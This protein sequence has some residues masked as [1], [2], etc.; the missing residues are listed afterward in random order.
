MNN[1]MMREIMDFFVVSGRY[2]LHN[3]LLALILDDLVV[4]TKESGS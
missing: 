3:D 2:R 1:R 4:V